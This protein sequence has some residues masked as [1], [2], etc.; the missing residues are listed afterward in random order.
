MTQFVHL[1][2][3][4]VRLGSVNFTWLVA[5]TYTSYALSLL[6]FMLVA[7]R[8]G[9]AGYGEVQAALAFVTLFGVLRLPGFDKVLI[10]RLAADG[11]GAELLYRRFLGLYLCTGAT[12]CACALCALMLGTATGIDTAIVLTFVPL[13]ITWPVASL[14]S[15][16]YQGRQQMKWITIVDLTRQVCYICGAIVVLTVWSSATARVMAVAIVLATSY[17]VGLG[18]SLMLVRRF[19]SR[20]LRPAWPRLSWPTWRSGL[21]LSSFV[22]F[23]YLFTKVDLVLAARYVGDADVGHYAAAMNMSAK[24][25]LPLSLAVTVAFPMMAQHLGPGGR[26][27]FQSLHAGILAFLLGG[28]L[29]ALAGHFVAAPLISLVFGADFA[30]AAEPFIILLWAGALTAGA[31]PMTTYLQAT[32]REVLML[33]ALPLRGAVNLL[34]DYAALT[35]GRGIVGVAWASVVA[36]AAFAIVLYVLVT[37]EMRRPRR[38]ISARESERNHDQGTPPSLD[39][40]VPRGVDQ[41]ESW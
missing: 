40:L 9:A 21:I 32:G 36:S 7:R 12:A 29:L 24:V 30:G 3:K 39:T 26:L 37:L 34:L 31:L 15:A 28:S 16:V 18:T 17:V 22:G 33:W 41:A 27:S 10:R 20:P 1:V 25:L 4:A 23:T 38:R 11:T 19:V 8:L 14:L 2:G 6:T 35:T 13:L 5:G